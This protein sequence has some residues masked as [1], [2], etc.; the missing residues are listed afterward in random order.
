MC[1]FLSILPHFSL[2]S[3]L[4][5]VVGQDFHIA[6]EERREFAGNRNFHA[7]QEKHLVNGVPILCQV[8]PKSKD[9]T[10]IPQ[11]DPEINLPSKHQQGSEEN[12]FPLNFSKFQCFYPSV[13]L[14]SVLH[15]MNEA[16]P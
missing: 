15:S 4:F 13:P 2:T 12:F 6:A 5:A 8:H 14:L 1:L 11:S 10:I 7:R 16:S 9:S 3:A